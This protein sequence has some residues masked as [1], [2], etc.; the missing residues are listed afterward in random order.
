MGLK[1]CPECGRLFV[2][3]PSGMCPACYEKVEEDELKVVE[4]LRDTRKASL[5]EIHEA[6]GVKEGI[7]MRMIK[8][9]RL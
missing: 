4:Y 9:G 2:E 6:T 8:R 3:N 5:K 1:N 7:I